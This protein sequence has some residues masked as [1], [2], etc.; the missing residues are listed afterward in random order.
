MPQTDRQTELVLFEVDIAAV[1]E[2]DRLIERCS[3]SQT[4]KQRATQGGRQIR[5]GRKQSK[6]DTQGWG[7]RGTGEAND[8]S[9]TMFPNVVLFQSLGPAF[10][11]P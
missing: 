6:G 4:G 3:Q 1:K 7:G 10:G 11:L 5:Q 2:R 8:G 9:L